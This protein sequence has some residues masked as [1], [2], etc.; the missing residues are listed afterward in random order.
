MYVLFMN[1]FYFLHLNIAVTK[2]HTSKSREEIE[3][4]FPAHCV[5]FLDERELDGTC[6]IVTG[7]KGVEHEHQCEERSDFAESCV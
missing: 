1:F 3:E 7:R 2:N 5:D 4:N 6:G